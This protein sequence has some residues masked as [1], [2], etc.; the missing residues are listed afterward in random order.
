[1]V[2]QEISVWWRIFMFGGIL[3]FSACGYPPLSAAMD[4]TGS[5]PCTRNA[6]CPS[7]SLPACDTDQHVCVTCFGNSHDLCAGATPRCDHD[8]CVAWVDDSQDC[9]GGVCLLSG[10]CADG[11][12]IIHA[13]SNGSLMP[14]CGSVTKPCSLERALSL[15]TSAKNLIKLDNAA[16]P[17]VPSAATFTIDVD[18]TI[19]M[20]NAT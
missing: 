6:D 16:M 12:V 4:A 14:D 17:F 15:V 9:L 20:R 1:M 8:A 3:A 5:D 13:T 7:A 18:V 2:W 10:A 19:D 11:N